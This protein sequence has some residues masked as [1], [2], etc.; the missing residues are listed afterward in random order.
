MLHVLRKQQTTKSVLHSPHLVGGSAVVPAQSWEASKVPAR[1]LS[2]LKLYNNTTT[3]TAITTH[4]YYYY[5]G[6]YHS[7]TITITI[8]ITITARRLRAGPR[9]CRPARRPVLRA[10]PDTARFRGNH[11]SNATCLPQCFFKSGEECSTLRCSSTR[12]NT[13]KTNESALDT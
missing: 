4:D 13:H 8:I 9:D 7:I 6:Y 5:C 12:R 1:L 2:L 10:S 3:T 11:L